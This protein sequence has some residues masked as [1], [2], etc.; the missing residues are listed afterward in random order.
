MSQ[1]TGNKNTVRN[2]YNLVMQRQK[3]LI[4]DGSKT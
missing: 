4:K 1:K 2:F 3:N